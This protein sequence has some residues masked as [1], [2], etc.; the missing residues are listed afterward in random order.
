MLKNVGEIDHKCSKFT[1]FSRNVFQK[2][3]I[4]KKERKNVLETS[5]QKVKFIFEFK[6][7]LFPY[8]RGSLHKQFWRTNFRLKDITII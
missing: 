7:T 8:L 3:F 2:F 5:K 1:R 4:A 6:K